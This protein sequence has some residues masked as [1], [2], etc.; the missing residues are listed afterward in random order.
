MLT[1]CIGAACLQSSKVSV[2][3]RMWDYMESNPTVFVATTDD[4]VQKVRS[5]KGKYAFLHQ[6]EMYSS[7]EVSLDSRAKFRSPPRF[8][9]QE[10]GLGLEIRKAKISVTAGLEANIMV[11]AWVSKVG[12]RSMSLASAV[13][14]PPRHPHPRHHHQGGRRQVRVPAGVDD[15]R[16]LQ[17]AQ[18]VQHDESRR[19]PR[20]QGIRHRHAHRIRS[21]VRLNIEALRRGAV[22]PH[23]LGELGSAVSSPSRVRDGAPTAERFPVFCGLKAGYCYVIK[24]KTAAEVPHLHLTARGGVR[25]PSWRARNYTT[26][27]LSTVTQEGV[28]FPDPPG[29]LTHCMQR[30]ETICGHFSFRDGVWHS[31]SWVLYCENTKLLVLTSANINRFSTSMQRHYRRDALITETARYRL[32]R[33]MY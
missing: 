2:Y 12:S 31:L 30:P 8:W 19:Q 6:P 24:G 10:L 25:Q 11:S 32:W 29:Q 16:V 22:F 33:L 26:I 20:L 7:L 18:A 21:T 23:Q 1:K 17:P 28:Q 27:R 14:D 15:E 9:S 13:L 4:G 5:S 3:A